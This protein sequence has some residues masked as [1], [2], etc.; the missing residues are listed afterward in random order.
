MRRARTTGVILT[1]GYIHSRGRIR[2]ALAQELQ[3]SESAWDRAASDIDQ[4]LI[5][6]KEANSEELKNL[7]EFPALEERIKI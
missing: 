5:N 2:C 4:D 3:Q 1:C 7:N 6:T